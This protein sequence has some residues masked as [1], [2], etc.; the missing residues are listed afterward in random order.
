MV[1]QQT[2]PSGEESDSALSLRGVGF[3]FPAEHSG[4]PLTLPPPSLWPSL[5]L[6]SLALYLA[7]QGHLL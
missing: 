2:Q 3:P 6:A 5:V 4:S 7:A 1:G